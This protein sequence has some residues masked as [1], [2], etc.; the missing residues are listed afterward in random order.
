MAAA[1]VSPSVSVRSS[2]PPPNPSRDP[3]L[4][5]HAGDRLRCPHQ[6]PRSASAVGRST[7]GGTDVG[8]ETRARRTR[9]ERSSASRRRSCRPLRPR[10]P[11]TSRS[12][13]KKG[14]K[15]S[16]ALESWVAMIE[17]RSVGLPIRLASKSV[18]Q[19]RGDNVSRSNRPVRRPRVRPRNRL[20]C[21]WSRRSSRDGS[22]DGSRDQTGERANTGDDG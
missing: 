6:I 4:P 21:A 9:G 1:S 22:F 19:A 17:S 3:R 16:P 12:G 7:T 18:L 20:S 14:Q 13:E 10:E 15:P 11:T 5:R 8:G 2:D